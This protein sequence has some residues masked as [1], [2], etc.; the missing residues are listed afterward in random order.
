MVLVGLSRPEFEVLL[1]IPSNPPTSVPKNM[2]NLVWMLTES[3]KLYDPL[4]AQHVGWNY[5]ARIVE[6]ILKNA[7]DLEGEVLLEVVFM[8][9][10]SF[11]SLVRANKVRLGGSARRV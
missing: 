8:K 3:L 11:M 2:R 5:L 1:E 6:H 4:A 9:T 7:H 10:L